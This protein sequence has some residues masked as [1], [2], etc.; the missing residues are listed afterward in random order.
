MP[1]IPDWN[2]LHPLVVHFPIALLMIAPVL[3]AVGLV[4]RRERGVLTAAFLV[5]A[6]GTV[7]AWVAVA[8]GESAGELADRLPGVESILERHEELAE[9]TRNVFTVLTLA[10]AGLLFVPWALKRELSRGVRLAGY[11]VLLAAHVA[12]LG[13]LAATAHQGGRLVHEKGVHAMMSPQRQVSGSGT[14]VADGD[15]DQD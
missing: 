7:A 10:F 5:V 6:M 13:S 14:E 4:A 9:T 1:P 8:T 15:R 2:A 12:G 11:G 3:I